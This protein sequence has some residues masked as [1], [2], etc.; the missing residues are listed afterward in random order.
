M[1]NC[2]P[3]RRAT[4]VHVCQQRIAWHPQ[5]KSALLH[6]VTAFS[7]RRRRPAC[8]GSWQPFLIRFAFVSEHHI[9][10]H[11]NA[12]D[13]FFTGAYSAIV[14]AKLM[15]VVPEFALTHEQARRIVRK[16][17]F[18]LSYERVARTDPLSIGF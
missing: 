14:I 17:R 6:N 1:F 10:R 4:A 8:R 2:S 5:P 15:L 18:P 7:H 11:I 12:E 3:G 16:I 9:Y 13:F